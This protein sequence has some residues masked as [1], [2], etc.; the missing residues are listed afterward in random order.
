[1]SGLFLEKGSVGDPYHPAP[2]LGC[3]FMLVLICIKSEGSGWLLACLPIH[4]LR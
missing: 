4:G 2:L 3:Q 1:M